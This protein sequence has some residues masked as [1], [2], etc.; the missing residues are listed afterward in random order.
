[1]ARN[2]RAGPYIL[3]CVLR[4]KFPSFFKKSFFPTYRTAA[5]KVSLKVKFERKKTAAGDRSRV[6]KCGRPEGRNAAR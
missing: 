5:E 4:K 1:L 2:E 6:K 3:I